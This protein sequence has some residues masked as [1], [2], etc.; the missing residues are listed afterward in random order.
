LR[1]IAAIEILRQVWIQNFSP[2][3]GRGMQWRDR[4]NVPPGARAI[5]SPYDPEAHY[6]KKRDKGWLGYKV[7]VTESG[8]EGLPHLI[9]HIHT[10]A[11]TMGDNDALPAIHQALEHTALL[12]DT[13]LVDT[14]YVEVKRVIESR[15]DYGVD[16]FGPIPGNHRWQFQQGAGFDLASFHVDWQAQ[17]VTCPKGKLSSLL[18]P[19]GDGRG[20][21]VMR[22]VFK[23]DDCSRCESWSQCTSAAGRRR[24]ITLKPQPLYEVLTAARE[25]QQTEAFK[26]QYKQRAG[27]EGSIS[28]GVRAFGL[29]RSRY[30]GKLKHVCS[31]SR[32]PPR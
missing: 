1:E 2:V 14:G 3:E 32:S 5:N 9:T 23:R 22:A 13:H 16:L 11:A 24:T 25:R 20:N 12:P 4:D 29:R 8:E 6:S 26:E 19:D 15:D 17:R 18:R 30:W 31:T 7:H 10:T 28:Q 21:A 27:I